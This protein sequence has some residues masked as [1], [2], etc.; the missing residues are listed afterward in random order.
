MVNII[1]FFRG[2]A[3]EQ[4]LIDGIDAAKPYWKQ[5]NVFLNTVRTQRLEHLKVVLNPLRYLLLT[6][7][8]MC[9]FLG[10][11]SLSTDWVR[12][13]PLAGPLGVIFAGLGSLAGIGL[14]CFLGIPIVGI[15]STVPFI[16]VGEYS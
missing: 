8:I 10:G 12:A 15:T 16:M 6:G 11:T 4:K 7:F 3:W 13:K 1:K 5:I 2:Y 14:V 9:I